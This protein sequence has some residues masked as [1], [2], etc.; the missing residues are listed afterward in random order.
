MKA[1][2]SKIRCGGMSAILV[3]ALGL[4]VLPASV[5]SGAQYPT[6]NGQP[7]HVVVTYDRDGVDGKPQLSYY[8]TLREDAYRHPAE[9]RR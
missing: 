8:R 7:L 2:K 3:L 1:T 5:A 6:V 4:M 9:R